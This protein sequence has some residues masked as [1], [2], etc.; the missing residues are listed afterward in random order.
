[1]GDLG[2]NANIGPSYVVLDARVSKF[3]HVQ[4]LRVEA[5]FEAFNA[6]NKV[7]FGTPA[8][9]LRSAQFGTSTGLQGQMRQVELGLR[10]DF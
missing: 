4:R 2:R 7:N 9:N 6:T 1:M 5:F 3:I 8:G 10:I